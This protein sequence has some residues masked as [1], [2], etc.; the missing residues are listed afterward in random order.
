MASG[1]R[2]CLFDGLANDVLLVLTEFLSQRDL[3]ALAR[4]CSRLFGALDHEIYASDVK[5]GR[6]WSLL[7]AV[8]NGMTGTAKKALAARADTETTTTLPAQTRDRSPLGIYN[9]TPLT[10]AAS[11]SDMEMAT[12]LVQAGAVVDVHQPGS[13]LWP[14]ADTPLLCAVQQG[15]LE[16]TKY[17][18]SAGSIDANNYFSKC[19]ASLLAH[20]AG[21]GHVHIIEHLLTIVDDPDSVKGNGATAFTRAVRS[22]MIDAA[23]ILLESGR[24]DPNRV[25]RDGRTA[26]SMAMN[27]SNE[28]TVRFLLAI[29][30]L[31]PNLSD[32]RGMPPILH[33]LMR[34][35][36]SIVKLLI[37]SDR[38]DIPGTDFLRTAC[39]MGLTDLIQELLHLDEF[40][41]VT[42]DDY[43]N[44]WLHIAAETGRTDIVKLLLKRPGVVVDEQRNDGKT[45]LM[46]A[47]EHTHRGVTTAL[48]KAGADV[49]ALCNRGFSVMHYAAQTTNIKLMETLLSKNMSLAAVTNDG[50]TALHLACQNGDPRIVKMMLESGACPITAAAD[51]TTPIHIAC[52]NR[53]EQVTQLLLSK[54]PL[55]HP[56]L[57]EGVTPLLAACRA[58]HATIVKHLFNHGANPHVTDLDG[59][60]PLSLACK[61]GH[62]TIAAMLLDRGAD[63]LEVDERGQTLLHLACT[64]RTPKVAFLLLKHGADATA[65]DNDDVTPLHE[66][67]RRGSLLLVRA[68]LKNG[69]EVNAVESVAGSTPLHLACRT[70]D[71]SQRYEVLEFLLENGA[72]VHA[73][74]QAGKTALHIACLRRASMEAL[75]LIKRGADPLLRNE[76]ATDRDHDTVFHSA[77][78]L[79]RDDEANT[80]VQS[81]PQPPPEMFRSGWTPLHTAAAHARVPY[82]K[83]LIGRG[84]D[85]MALTENGR[86]ALHEVL[87]SPRIYPERKERAV[88]ALIGAG[89]EVNHR[90]ND[91][92]TAL[93]LSKRMEK[94]EAQRL[95]EQALIENGAVV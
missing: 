75:L 28:E 17:L 43:G 55:S 86:T 27:G 66:A 32:I 9:L 20:A 41:T 33:A 1:R 16:M 73:K 83:A 4:T 12:L 38:V 8:C 35:N 47:A 93:S 92:V 58:G 79:W 48:L 29:P 24:V 59:S 57:C 67:C 19:G 44:S 2:F 45:P 76:A 37:T 52:T 60:T 23:R 68:L 70:T 39:E 34:R 85:P 82:I 3:N 94:S 31:D 51:G 42:R 81:I 22:G 64:F 91:G 13:S 49:N 10:I 11:R 7:W 30:S 18:L 87:L 88:Q 78:A 72:D 5:R 6:S 26:F 74:T 53:W 90:D 61:G 14:S 71:I 54:T 56:I 89:V 77:C 46:S 36:V 69:A 63:K 80:I 50:Q 62:P 21:A 95:I 84:C 40:R 15:S 65:R 25:N